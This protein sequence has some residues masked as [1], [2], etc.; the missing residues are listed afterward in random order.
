M[1]E[2]NTNPFQSPKTEINSTGNRDW[3]GAR[4]LAGNLV[5]TPEYLI[6]S[7]EHFQSQGYWYR[8]RK[9]IRVSAAAF[10]IFFAIVG[11]F[12]SNFG[13]SAFLIALSVFFLL[14]YKI[15]H[16]RL[17]RQI[18]KSPF[19]NKQQSIR[20]SEGGISSKS[21]LHE[22]MTKWASFKQA[23]LFED[24]VMLIQEPATLNWFPDRIFDN[25]SDAED[26]RILV[27]SKLAT[28]TVKRSGSGRRLI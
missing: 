17:K 28:T 9:W 16:W 24:G 23:I 2:E 8:V 27:K 5:V 14:S 21:E 22:F 15:D 4:E 26:L 3:D 13:T 25:S 6:D 11:L 20:F 18:S 19:V 1:N 12:F 7:L 10:L